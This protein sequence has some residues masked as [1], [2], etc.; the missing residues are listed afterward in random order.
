MAQHH[1][2]PTPP[3]VLVDGVE[4]P[5][6][7]IAAEMQHH[8]AATAAE[9]WQ[10][11]AQ[12]V[13]LRRLLLA[14]AE[15]LAIDDTPQGDETAEEAT[16]RRLLEA[17][18]RIPE[19][20]EETCR[21]WFAANPAKFRTKPTWHAAHILFAADPADPVER[22]AARTAALAALDEVLAN[23][24]RLSDLAR[25][26]SACPSRDQGGDLGLIE[27]GSTVAPF[28]EALRATPSG[29]THPA[30]VETR[31]GF[32]VLR[33]LHHAEGRDLPYDAVRER[34]AEWLHEASWRRAAHQYMA[35]LTGRARIE[36]VAMSASADTPLVQ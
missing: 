35:L 31:F 11:A 20:D 2:H 36:G 10:A 14:E 17:E 34:I 19:A 30:V 16:L 27:P 8:P 23:P 21:R 32:H 29:S 13:V 28:E 18:L 7:E 33:V 3:P 25:A 1:H 6:A 24:I 12:A 5:P 9:A 22:L 15:R 26:H 4:I